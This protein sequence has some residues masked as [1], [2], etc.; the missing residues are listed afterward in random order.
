M[1]R[2]PVFFN[3]SGSTVDPGVA[4]TIFPN[5]PV[6]SYTVFTVPPAKLFVLKYV[7][8]AVTHGNQAYPA[9][10]SNDYGAVGYTSGNN[11]S[12]H[13][14]PF[15]RSE[16]GGMLVAS[17]ALNVYIPAGAQVIVKVPL[18]PGQPGGASINVNGYYV[19]NQ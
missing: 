18:I 4:G 17:L 12:F 5:R 3:A 6:S 9:G 2:E 13:F 1:D 14:I 11:Q 15:S 10:N 19:S 8:A 7:S 16:P